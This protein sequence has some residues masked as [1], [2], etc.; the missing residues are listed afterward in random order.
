[1]IMFNIILRLFFSPGHD[2]NSYATGNYISAHGIVYIGLHAREIYGHAS[3]SKCHHLPVE[4]P[5]ERIQL[6][7]VQQK[8]IYSRMCKS[9]V[10]YLLT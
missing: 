2:F 5:V 6:V 9:Y 8:T 1:M 7:E 10:T 4:F 3:K